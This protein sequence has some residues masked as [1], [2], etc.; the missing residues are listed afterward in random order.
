MGCK[1]ANTITQ[2]VQ[3][4]IDSG[5]EIQ[6]LDPAPDRPQIAFSK[7]MGFQTWMQQI[8][9]KGSIEAEEIAFNESSREEGKDQE[10]TDSK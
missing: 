3:D 5:G 7:S 8:E 4:F 10:S 2:Q 9:Q 6:Y 1:V